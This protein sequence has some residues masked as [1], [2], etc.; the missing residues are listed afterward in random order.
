MPNNNFPSF[1][2]DKIAQSIEAARR[3]HADRMRATHE[4][5]P[6]GMQL[7]DG[8]LMMAGGCIE[9]K[10]GDGKVC[11]NLPLGLGSHCLPIPGWVPSGTPAKACISI[12]TKWGIP[13]GVEVSVTVGGVVVVKQGFGCSC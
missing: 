10:V 2:N 6:E 11:L 7:A 4:A 9:V 5:G 13:C 12:C 8:A 1:D 3:H